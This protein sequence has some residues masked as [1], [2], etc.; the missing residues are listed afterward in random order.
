MLPLLDRIRVAAV[1]AEELRTNNH[2]HEQ[3]M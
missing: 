1:R 3:S 2:P